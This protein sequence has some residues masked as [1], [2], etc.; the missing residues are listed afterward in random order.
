MTFSGSLAEQRVGQGL[1][2][3]PRDIVLDPQ[4]IDD[5]AI[6]QHDLLLFAEEVDVAR[7]GHV[8]PVG[9]LVGQPADRPT[10]DHVLGDDFLAILRFDAFVEHVADDHRR[11]GRA[12]AQAAGADD[13]DFVLKVAVPQLLLDRRPDQERAG[14]DATGAGAKANPLVPGGLGLG[15]CGAKGVTQGGE[16][17]NRG[18]HLRHDSPPLLAAGCPSRYWS[19]IFFSRVGFTRW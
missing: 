3:V 19:R 15:R 5:A 2:A 13:G 9:P 16:F 8:A 12:G 18:D 7:R 4:G 1:V 6:A 17:F 11:P 14:S 10:L